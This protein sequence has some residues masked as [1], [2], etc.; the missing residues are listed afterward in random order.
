MFAGG[1]AALERWVLPVATSATLAMT[2]AAARRAVRAIDADGEL[3]RRNAALCTRQV[4]V[5]D[6]LDGM[7]TFV[8]R[9]T[10]E[11]AHAVVTVIDTLAHDPDCA[12]ACG[13]TMGERRVEAFAQLVL[14]AAGCRSAAGSGPRLEA[15]LDVVVDLST[16]LGLVR[17]TYE[18]SD[19]LLAYLVARDETCRFPG[20]G[21]RASRCQGDHAEGWDDGGATSIE[22]LGALCLRHHQL[23]THG[24]WRILRS[25]RDGSRIWESPAKRRYERRPG[26]HSRHSR[27]RSSSTSCPTRRHS[28]NSPRF[29]GLADQRPRSR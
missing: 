22:N 29:R 7:S 6:D 5:W 2:R 15:R 17:R 16:L 13:A 23:K 18:V 4:N 10:T 21:R 25:E 28:D 1:C 9:M 24:G 27:R 26:R 11:S 14:G 3:R 8:A 20:C 12:T 19:R